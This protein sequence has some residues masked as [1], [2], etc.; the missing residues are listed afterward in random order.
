MEF[1]PCGPTGAAPACGAAIVHTYTVAVNPVEIEGPHGVVASRDGRSFY[2]SMAHGRPFD[3][4][5]LD[6]EW[7][8]RRKFASYPWMR[9]EVYRADDRPTTYYDRK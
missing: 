6:E 8:R 9:P 5:T 1:R 7:P 3:A 2:V 4:G